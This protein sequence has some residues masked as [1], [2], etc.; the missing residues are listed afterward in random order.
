MMEENITVS[1]SSQFALCLC[2]L[3]KEICQFFAAAATTFSPCHMD[4]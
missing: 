3:E 2:L 4:S 1:P